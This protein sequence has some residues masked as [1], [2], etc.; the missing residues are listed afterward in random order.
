MNR[1][2]WLVELTSMLRV[3]WFKPQGLIVPSKVRISVGFPKC[4]G[5]KGNKAIGQCWAASASADGFNEIFI[6]PCL[7][8]ADEVVPTLIHELLHAAVGLEHGH[9]APFKRG[10]E[11]V[12]L[13]GK[14]TATVAGQALIATLPEWLDKLPAYPHGALIPAAIAAKKQGTRLLKIVCPAC[15]Y[16]ARITQKWIDVGYPTCPCGELMVDS[17]STEE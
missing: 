14:A 5:T 4:G 17:S 13:E 10:M 16:T 2:Q 12:G 1:E 3:D 15:E 6:H 9:K 7:V 8:R 11:K